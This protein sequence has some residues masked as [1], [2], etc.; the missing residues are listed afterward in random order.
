[1][2]RHRIG[3]S[4]VVALVLGTLCIVPRVSAQQPPDPRQ[5]AEECIE[6]VR[7]RAGAR[8]D[9]NQAVA[10]ECI[11]VIEEHLANGRHEQAKH[12][13]RHCIHHIRTRTRATMF[14]VWDHCGDCIRRLRHLDASRLAF[15]VR[16]VCTHALDRLRHSGHRAAQAILDA[17]PPPTS[18]SQMELLTCE[19]DINGTGQVDSGDLFALF[20]AWGTDAAVYF[21]LDGDATLTFT[22]VMVMIGAWG[23]CD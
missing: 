22:D 23:P 20:G 7:E 9:R 5:I 10:L 16:N 18:A 3:S 15:R 11:A 13:A 6:R 2:K 14:Q 4:L 8:I 17:F 12:A 19:S 1:M 21:D